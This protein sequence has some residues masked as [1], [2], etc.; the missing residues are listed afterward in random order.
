[1]TMRLSSNR[2]L[3]RLSWI[4]LALIFVAGMIIT[5]MLARSEIT[6]DRSRDDALNTSIAASVAV[7]IG[8]AVGEFYTPTVAGE[9]FVS[10][11]VAES[12]D[13]DV[14]EA[15]ILDTSFEPFVGPIVA[16]LGPA[17]LDY[18]LAPAGV[19]TYS[20]RPDENAA[21]IGHNLFLDDSRRETILQTVE[22]RQPIVSGPVDLIQ[23][24]TGLIIRQAIFLPGLAPFTERYEEWAADDQ[25]YPWMEVVPDDFWGFATTVIDFNELMAGID[26]QGLDADQYALR[27]VNANG[28]VGESIYGEHPEPT[29]HTVGQDVTLPDGSRWQFQVTVVRTPLWHLWPIFLAGLAATV[30]IVILV[31]RGYSV[32]RRNRLGFTY[33]TAIADVVEPSEILAETSR[34]LAEVIPDARGSVGSV[35]LEPIVVSIPPHDAPI[36]SDS[37]T[38]ADSRASNSWPVIQAGELQAVIRIEDTGSHVIRRMGE[39]VD[40]ISTLLAASLAAVSRHSELE[41]V[42]RID[43]LTDVFNRRQFQPSFDELSEV[44]RRRNLHLAVGVIDIDDFKGINDSFGHLF[45]DEALRELGVALSHAVRGQDAVFR[46]GG[47]EFVV[48]CLLPDAADSLHMFERIKASA[49]R[50]LSEIAPDQRIVTISIG[51]VVNPPTSIQPMNELLAKAD[52]ALYRAKNA[53]RD[54]VED[55]DLIGSATGP[56]GRIG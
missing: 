11:A 18:Q 27:S 38:A 20:A 47:D 2:S 55:W 1:M 52:Q 9:G 49:N 21:A 4:Y 17:L 53:G 15:Q 13:L 6:A 48:L 10:S 35:V 44:A 3:F 26:F 31:A 5:G 22:Q 33:S 50:A 45:G 39:A 12:R 16:Y 46:F 28:Q 14:S 56:V 25:T 24:G 43:Q 34:F 36:P 37:P 51:Y 54:R 23:G 19:V 42:S 32:W 41:R 29:V 30:V 8:T 7:Q 40:L